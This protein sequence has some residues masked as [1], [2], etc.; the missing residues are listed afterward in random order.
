MIENFISNLFGGKVYKKSQRKS[1][2]KSYKKSS[3]K[4]SKKHSSPKIRASKL[5]L[6]AKRLGRNGK[7]YQVVMK[8]KKYAWKLCT[9]ACIGAQEGPSPLVGKDSGVAK[10]RRSVRKSKKRSSSKLK[11]GAK[12]RSVRK[13]KKSVKKSKKRSSKK[14]STKK[15]SSKK[16][17]SRKMY[18]GDESSL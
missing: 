18:G 14:R 10:K 6:G 15:R 13:S 8:G 7:M 16:R 2:K 17:S 3:K 12:R 1:V 4:S 11:G 5:T 9:G